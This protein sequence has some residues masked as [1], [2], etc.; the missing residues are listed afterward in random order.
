MARAHS[1]SEGVANRPTRGS[2]V[3]IQAARGNSAPDCASRALS[4]PAVT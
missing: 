4:Q 2:D 3:W 1:G